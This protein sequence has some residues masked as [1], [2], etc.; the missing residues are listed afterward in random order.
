MKINLYEIDKV[1]VLEPAG[2]IMGGE[3]VILLEEKLFSLLG[4]GEKKV[5]VDLGKTYWVSSPAVSVLLNHNI[6]FR[7]IGGSLKLAN[8]T[9]KIEEIITITRL[10][11]FFEVYDN[12]DEALNSFKEQKDTRKI[13][14]SVQ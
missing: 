6:R 13:L 12:L 3:G 5:V 1:A 4:R 10:V 2:K 11:S 8:L 7:E 14:E 9:N